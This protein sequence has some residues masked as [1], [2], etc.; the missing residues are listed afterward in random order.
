MAAK[1]QPIRAVGSARPSHLMFTGG[2]GAIVDLPNMAA[3]VDGLDFWEPHYRNDTRAVMEPRLLDEVRRK[4]GRKVDELRLIPLSEEDDKSNIGVPVRPFPAWLRCTKCN[5]LDSIE[6]KNFTYVNDKRKRPD[7]ARF[8]HRNCGGKKDYKA[9]PARFLLACRAGHLDE[10][11]Y[12]W[13]V[14]RGTPCPKAEKP[15]LTMRDRAGNRA[16]NVLIRCEDCGSERNLRDAM[17]E[18][19]KAN[20]PG[21]RGRHPHLNTFD[22]CIEDLSPLI[23]GASNLWFPQTA[24]VLSVPPDSEDKLAAL[25]AEHWEPLQMVATLS[26]EQMAPLMRSLPQLTVFAEFEAT[27]L[28][29]AMDA[30]TPG[31]QGNDDR[32]DLREP[33]WK[34]F[35]AAQLPDDGRNFTAVRDPEGVPERLKPF[36]TDVVR[37][38]RLRE[39]RAFYGFTR[40]DAPDPEQPDLVPTAPVSRREPTWVPASEVFGEGLFLRV[41]AE[42]LRQWTAKVESSDAVQRLQ[43]AWRKFRENRHS[44]RLTGDFDPMAG[45]PGTGYVVLHTLSHLLIRSIALEC[46]YNSASLAERIYS[47]GDDQAGILI[48]TAVPDAEGTLGGLVSLAEPGQLTRIVGKAITG[49]ERCS[50]DPVC[51]DHLPADPADSLHG[52]ACHSCLFVSETTCERGNRFLD[53]RFV[54]DLGDDLAIFPAWA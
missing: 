26:A 29:A 35:T 50:G 24:S 45:W 22:D 3:L 12:E 42:A 23:V 49:A 17:G 52:A 5:R 40:L 33:E 48:Y 39:V 34:A 31:A 51:A 19:G 2:I 36:F 13:F 27:E 10:F 44:N 4:V 41:D 20:L 21:C 53:R 30:Y 38:E 54:A 37:A 14:H 43:S 47:N 11:P 6:S 16:V 1:Q 15:R 9:V 18:L 25:V 7:L 46:G 32:S 28:R 8:E